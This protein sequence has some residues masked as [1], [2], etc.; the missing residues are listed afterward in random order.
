MSL[1]MAT[2]VLNK[3]LILTRKLSH[4]NNK[5]IQTIPIIRDKNSIFF[6]T[7]GCVLISTKINFLTLRRQFDHGPVVIF[8]TCFNV[9]G[10]Y[11]HFF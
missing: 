3:L 1:V 6:W 5:R 8:F 10:S 11:K 9:W 4:K 2:S 7:V